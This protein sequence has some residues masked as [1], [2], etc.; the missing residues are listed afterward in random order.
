[1]ASNKVFENSRC[2]FPVPVVTR[3]NSLFDAAQNII[4]YKDKLV[5]TF[6]EL[7]LKNLKAN[8]WVFLE[9]FCKILQLLAMSLDK[10]QSE[11]RAF[12]VLLHQLF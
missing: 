8:E 6:G 10:L 7:N 11:K 9:E 5:S 12:W 1:V 2:K 4:S 3:W